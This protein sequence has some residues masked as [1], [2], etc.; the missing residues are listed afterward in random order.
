MK[1]NELIDHMQ[2]LLDRTADSGERRKLQRRI[3]ELKSEQQRRLRSDMEENQECRMCG[4]F[5]PKAIFHKVR[6]TYEV[7]DQV[8]MSSE[9]GI[10]PNCQAH[11]ANEIYETSMFPGDAPDGGMYDPIPHNDRYGQPC[12]DCGATVGEYH[13]NG[14]DWERCPV[15]GGQLLS[16]G[17]ADRVRLGDE[18]TR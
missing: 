1:T 4:R 10:C 8:I 12:H 5:H 18:V 17:H 11:V 16:C 7:D 13:K 6:V 2:W 3:A 15:C 9:K 14:C